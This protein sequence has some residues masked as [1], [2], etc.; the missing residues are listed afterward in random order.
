M[1]APL[2]LAACV[3]LAACGKVAPK[4]PLEASVAPLP[5][6][7]ACPSRFNFESPVSLAPWQAPS[8]A[9][10]FSPLSLDGTHTVCG[11]GALKTRFQ[12]NG[13]NTAVLFCVFA[14][15]ENV[16]GH[17]AVANFYFAVPPPS[18]L[19]MQIFFVD[20]NDNWL[21]PPGAS[22]YGLRQG[23]NQISE[24]FNIPG[25]SDV[26]GILFQF[27]TNNGV[28]YAGDLWVDEINW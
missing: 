6:A 24:S 8:W 13:S 14:Q 5:A 22:H 19:G 2:L 1:K 12:M 20:R 25:V 4:N 10:G 3:L 15:G 7:Y 17:L 23:W 11:T 9:G 27:T 18:D 16:T 26:I 21:N 28:A